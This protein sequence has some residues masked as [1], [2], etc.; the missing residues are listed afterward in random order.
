MITGSYSRVNQYQNRMSAYLFRTM[1]KQTEME[2]ALWKND[3]DGGKSTNTINIL[4][5]Y[6]PNIK[7]PRA[8]KR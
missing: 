1:K 4:H 6:Y 2:K 3:P 7:F 8:M 5:L